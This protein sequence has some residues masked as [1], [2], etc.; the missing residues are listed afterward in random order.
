MSARSTWR[1]SIDFAGFPVPVAVYPL[2]K[3]TTTESFKMLGRDGLP[4]KQQ[5]VQADGETIPYGDCGRGV[6]IGKDEYAPLS[7]EALEM[8]A[9]SEKS[10]VVEAEYFCPVSSLPTVLS[11]ESY[12]VLPDPKVA[13]SDR[14]VNVIWNGLRAHEMAYVT[15]VTF[16]A[17]SKDRVVAIYATDTGLIAR[18][19][20]FVEDLHTEVATKSPFV[21]DEKQ[22]E[23][24]GKFVTDDRVR[25]FSLDDF[26]S[27]YRDR[28]QEAI[29]QALD[30][31][32]L[33][34]RA[35]KPL[36]TADLMAALEAQLA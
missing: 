21:E 19:F 36:P 13:G 24:F 7:A 26:H 3:S 32:P 25:E 35:E 16:R 1:G 9:D 4:V 27:D 28:R 18:T 22:A 5:Y 20:P 29:R 33:P 6:E 34:T 17:G 31:K 23:L 15:K 11:T 14:S 30:G 12:S 10:T 2:V 8:I